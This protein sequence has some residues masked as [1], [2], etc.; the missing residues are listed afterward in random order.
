MLFGHGLDYGARRPRVVIGVASI[1]LVQAVRAQSWTL[2]RIADYG[3]LVPGGSGTFAH[4]GFSAP[5]IHNGRVAFVGQNQAGAF[6]GVYAWERGT[7]SV[8]ANTS[9][10]IPNGQGSFIGFPFFYP[11]VL[12]GAQAAFLGNGFGKVSIQQGIYLSSAGALE[13]VVDRNTAIPNS[14]STFFALGGPALDQGV[15]AF[16]GFSLNPAI[17]GVYRWQNAS[18]SVVA[19]HTTA[20][21]GGSGL[22]TSFGETAI[23]Q[24]V[25]AVA[26]RGTGGQTGLYLGHPGGALTRLYDT[27][28]PPPGSGGAYTLLADPSIEDGRVAFRGHTANGAGIYTD[29]SGALE[30]LAQTGMPVPG[31]P[32]EFY[33]SPAGPGLSNGFVVFGATFMSGGSGVFTNHGGAVSKIIASGDVLDGRI[34]DSIFFNHGHDG[35][36]VALGV[37]FTDGW[38]GVYMGVIPAPG[39][40]ALLALGLFGHARRRR[41]NRPAA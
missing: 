14:T 41:R 35:N 5:A 10:S 17:G 38:R 36:S 11:P 6:E 19:D 24:G 28:T 18:I 31:L 39:A 25:V 40:A 34:V 30:L 27:A 22:F 15:V 29:T 1:V 3:T 20:I 12:E 37:V 21:P 23:D 13:R 32:G 7:L 4:V 8:L 26:G 16:P 33:L 2:T 9:T